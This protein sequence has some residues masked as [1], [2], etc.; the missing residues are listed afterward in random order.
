MTE[1]ETRS[2][3]DKLRRELDAKVRAGARGAAPV[4]VGA[5][6]ALAGCTGTKVPE[7]QAAGVDGGVIDTQATASTTNTTSE[8]MRKTDDLG[9]VPP[10]MAPC[11]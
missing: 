5:G 2:V 4:V 7:Q 11:A 8:P 9:P 6:I 10:Y 3:L 1:N